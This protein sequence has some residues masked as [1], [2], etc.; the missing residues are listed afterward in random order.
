MAFLTKK[1]DSYYICESYQTLKVDDKGVSVKNATDKIVCK[2]K[3]IWTSPSKNQK[4]AEIEI[5]KY[6]EDND[7]GC[8][9]KE[10]PI[11]K[12]LERLFF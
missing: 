6:D 7:S 10:Q 3:I 4:L 1:C 11:Y 2:N 8:N 5:G 9:K 12:D